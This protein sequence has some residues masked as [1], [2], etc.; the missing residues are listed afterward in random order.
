MEITDFAV[1]WLVN[2][3]TDLTRYVVFAVSVWLI[4]WVVLARPLAGRKIR[5]E[6]PKPRQLLI[7]FGASLRSIAIFSTVGLATF[8][9][10]RADLRSRRE[11]R[12][13][14]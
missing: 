6:T 13:H 7:E 11:V 14:G 5:P 3:R 8:A 10:E 1:Q 9:L 4:L 2:M 12:N